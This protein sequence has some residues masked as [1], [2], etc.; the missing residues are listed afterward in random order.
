MFTAALFTT[1]KI[2]KQ[3]KCPSMDEWI[4]KMW[5]K[6]TH[7]HMHKLWNYIPRKLAVGFFMTL[8]G[9]TMSKQAKIINRKIIKLSL[10]KLF[11]VQI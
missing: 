10:K 7:T 11:F 2:W 5:F 6:H 9:L 8:Y 4:K 1:A 3:T